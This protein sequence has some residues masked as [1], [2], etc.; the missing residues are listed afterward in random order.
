VTEAADIRSAFPPLSEAP[1]MVRRFVVVVSLS[2]LSALPLRG[3]STAQFTIRVFVECFDAAAAW[4]LRIAE[5]ETDRRLR[6]LGI[7]VEWHDGAIRRGDRSLV[8]TFSILI[9]SP[10]MTAQKVRA[11]GITSATLATANKPA[12]RTYVFY[13]RVSREADRL[14]SQPGTLL[15]RVVTHELGHLLAELEHGS[16]GIMRPTLARSE[17]GYFDFTDA[18][19]QAIRRA[20]TAARPTAGDVM[21]TTQR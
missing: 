3:A 5:T 2:V 7:Y 11:E 15:G 21:A 19:K 14:G 16:L 1:F 4:P 6:S 9:L 12:R 18:E 20:L 13:D 8:P 17:A 10:E